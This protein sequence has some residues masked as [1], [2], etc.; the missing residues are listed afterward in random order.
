MLLQRA[1]REFILEKEFENLAPSTLKSYELLF[2][3]FLSWAEEENITNVEHVTSKVLKRYLVRCQTVKGNNPTSI[4]TK[5][6][7][8]R[9][10]FNFMK[11]EGHLDEN[12]TDSVKK[13]REE[14]RIKTFSD[15]EVKEIL[16]HLR[17]VQRRERS[18]FSVRNYIIFLTLIGT[19][20]RASELT[21]LKWKDVDLKNMTLRVFGKMKRDEIV[22]IDEKLSKELA[23][24]R[25][26][27]KERFGELSSSVF[28]NQK[29]N[30]ITVNALKCWFKRLAKEMSFPETRCSAHS[31]RHYFAKVWIQNGGDISTLAKVLRHSSIKTTE[32]YLHFFGNEVSEHHEKFNPLKK[33]SI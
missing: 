22:P 29:N 11:E 32:K 6:K 24:W 1:Y 14:I 27:C 3:D 2:N 30:A 25:D 5:R 7:L 26:Y 21:S 18:F 19:G 16:K 12:P 23:Y 4:N 15:N 9:A 20:L 13:V 17:R 33:L 8:F 10:F 31:C 28:V